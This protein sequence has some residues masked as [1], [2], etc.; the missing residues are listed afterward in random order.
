[1]YQT[2]TR[3]VIADGRSA[4]GSIQPILNCFKYVA[5]WTESQVQLFIR[6]K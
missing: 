1:M 4:D 3:Y 5:I 6:S 2:E